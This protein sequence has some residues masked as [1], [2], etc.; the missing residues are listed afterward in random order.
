MEA[1]QLYCPM[2]TTLKFPPYKTEC[3]VCNRKLLAFRP[4]PKPTP[5]PIQPQAKGPDVWAKPEA[6][7]APKPKV[8]PVKPVWPNKPPED[9]PT[10]FK[11]LR[12]KPETPKPEVPD[13]K[14][15]KPKPF[16][17]KPLVPPADPKPEVPFSWPKK[18]EPL[19]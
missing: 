1:G 17:P 10:P 8:E 12:T 3:T 4:E 2:H 15:E 9:L 7:E 16:V 13:P 18:T 11:D 5:A 6:P 14:V 19:K